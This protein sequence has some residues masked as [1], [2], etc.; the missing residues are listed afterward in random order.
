MNMGNAQR[1]TPFVDIPI[2]SNKISYNPLTI[3]FNVNGDMKSWM[4]LHNWMRSIASPEGFN[5]RN[6]LTEQ[7]SKRGTFKNYSDA[8]LTVL[9]NLNNP[10][11][12]FYFYNAFPTALSDIEF[13]T[14][15]SADNIVTGTASFLFEYYNFVSV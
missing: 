8:T 13:N 5:E 9:S 2:A 11:G 3:N 14:T 12:N 10:I 6:R 7:Q 1:H 15:E 4:D